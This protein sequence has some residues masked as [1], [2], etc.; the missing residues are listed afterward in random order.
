MCSAGEDEIFMVGIPH[1]MEEL[2]MIPHFPGKASPQSLNPITWAQMAV[3]SR[4]PAGPSR[5]PCV[6]TDAQ[7]QSP[8]VTHVWR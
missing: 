4:T 2:G 5:L 7:G 8:A 1:Q 6:G 3:G